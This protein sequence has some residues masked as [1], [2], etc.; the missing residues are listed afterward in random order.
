MDLA[1]IISVDLP[2][3][4]QAGVAGTGFRS[5]M[6]N[7]Y[8]AIVFLAGLLIILSTTARRD[9]KKPCDSSPSPSPIQNPNPSSPLISTIAGNGEGGGISCPC[10]RESPVPLPVRSPKSLDPE[11][12]ET[13]PWTRPRVPSNHRSRWWEVRWRSLVRHL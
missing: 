7:G 5:E 4:W 10:R 8:R 2:R 13:Q 11:P 9:R 1:F 12:T 6:V 3:D